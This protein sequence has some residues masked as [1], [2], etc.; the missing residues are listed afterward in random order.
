MTEELFETEPTEEVNPMKMEQI[1]VFINKGG[2]I[3]IT[4]EQF[5]APQSIIVLHPVQIPLLCKWLTDLVSQIPA[6]G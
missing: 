4:Q 2:S 3:S 5:E 6:S 1:E